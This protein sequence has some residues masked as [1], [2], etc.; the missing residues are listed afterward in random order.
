M[1][2]NV[3]ENARKTVEGLR[4]TLEKQAEAAKQFMNTQTETYS[5]LAKT[6]QDTVKKGVHDTWETFLA[7]QRQVAQRLRENTHGWKDVVETLQET[8]HVLAEEVRQNARTLREIWAPLLRR[9]KRGTGDQET[10][11]GPETSPPEASN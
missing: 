1:L 10:A 3:K 6:Y 11:S 8:Q 7:T 5:Q 4:E 2:D 9:D